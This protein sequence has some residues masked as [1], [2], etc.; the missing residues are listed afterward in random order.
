V[1]NTGSISGSYKTSC[2]SGLTM[3]LFENEVILNK[4]EVN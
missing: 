1:F 3:D 2:G 4:W